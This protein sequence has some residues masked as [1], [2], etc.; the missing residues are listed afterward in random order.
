MI[1]T[2]RTYFFVSV[3]I[4]VFFSNVKLLGLFVPELR[5][6]EP[7]IFKGFALTIPA[8]LIPLSSIFFA[9]FSF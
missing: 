6:T 9:S 5:I 2:S 8:E 3:M 7:A 1:Q 4:T